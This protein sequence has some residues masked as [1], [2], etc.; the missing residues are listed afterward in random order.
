MSPQEGHP[1]LLL[2]RAAQDADKYN[3]GM[4]IPGYVHVVHRDQA[5]LADLELTADDLADF[6]LQ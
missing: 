2:F 1:P 4:Q 5:R 6:A 3:C